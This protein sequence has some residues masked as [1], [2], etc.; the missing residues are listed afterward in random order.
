M[1][2]SSIPHINKNELISYKTKAKS[3]KEVCEK[4]EECEKIRV[5]KVMH[6]GTI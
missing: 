3:I 4:I 1:Q 5:M 2:D 6:S